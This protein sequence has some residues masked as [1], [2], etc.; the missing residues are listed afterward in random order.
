MGIAGSEIRVGEKLEWARAHLPVVSVGAEVD[1]GG[2]STAAVLGGGGYGA[3]AVLRR[4]GGGLAGP[5]SF[6]V[7][8]GILLRGGLGLGRGGGAGRRGGRG[9]RRGGLAPASSGGRSGQRRGP[10][11]FTAVRGKWLRG[12]FGRREVGKGCSAW[13]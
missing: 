10:V 4:G 3:P 12:W 8:R 11:S 13:S 5:R 6:G 7:A 1:C 2:L 9:R